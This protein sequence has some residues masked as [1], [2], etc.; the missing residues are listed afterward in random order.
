MAPGKDVV[1]EKLVANL[2]HLPPSAPRPGKPQADPLLD[3]YK[4][5][6]IIG[7]PGLASISL[8]SDDNWPTHAPGS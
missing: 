4:G 1:G 3:D 7:G 5:M 2:V 6:T 8:I